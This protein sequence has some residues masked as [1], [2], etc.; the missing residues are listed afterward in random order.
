MSVGSIQNKKATAAGY[1][2]AVCWQFADHICCGRASACNHSP[3]HRTRHCSADGSLTQDPSSNASDPRGLQ[4][5][6]E[7][8]MHRPQ[9]RRFSWA[10][11]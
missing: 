9:S 4:A 3:H 5:E 2:V 10:T 6:V 11:A 1:G 8:G 7:L